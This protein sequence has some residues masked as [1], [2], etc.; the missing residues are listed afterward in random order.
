MGCT[1]SVTREEKLHKAIQQNHPAADTVAIYPTLLG[2]PARNG[3]VGALLARVSHIALVVRDVGNSVQFYAQVLGF[4]QINRPN[5]DR[6]G[7]WLSMGNLE[8]HL[9]KGTPHVSRGQHP[10]DLIVSHIA[11]EVTDAGVVLKRLRDLRTELKDFSWRQNVSVPT[12]ET[13]LAQRFDKDHTSAEGQLQQYFLE[14]PDGYWIE[15]CNCGD[16]HSEDDLFFSSIPLGSLAK[17]AW[18]ALR[19]EKRARQRLS[20]EHIQTELAALVPIESHAVSEQKFFNFRSRQNIY[21]DVCQGFTTA[22]LWDALAK[23]GDHVPGAILLLSTWRRSRAKVYIPPRFFDSS[24][25]V[26]QAC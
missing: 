7:A 18:R 21:G 26:A 23:A 16:E 19:W 11:L 13:S 4:R 10:H 1:Q 6:H 14:D 22:E 5:F 2:S 9:I 24:G 15:L 25:N 8:L 12:Q 20:E 3:G 17:L